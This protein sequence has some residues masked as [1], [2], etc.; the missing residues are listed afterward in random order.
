ML[1]FVDK[2]EIFGEMSLFT[3]EARS[4][5]AEALEQTTTLAIYRIQFE[6]L[7]EE[8]GQIAMQIIRVLSKRLQQT[9]TQVMDVLFRDARSRV[10]HTLVVLGERFGTP[11]QDAVRITIRLTHQELASLV[12]TARET[13]SRILAELQDEGRL[14]IC[15]HR[16][17]IPDMA[18]LKLQTELL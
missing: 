10:I 17:V 3:G 4:A 16:L 8:H 9:N 18:A 5:T 15:D 7:L 13:V 1:A 11:E 12:G 2:G 14:E 6:Q